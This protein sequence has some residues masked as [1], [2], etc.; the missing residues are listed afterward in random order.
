[1]PDRKGQQLGNYKLLRLLGEG[2]FAE[3]YLGEQVFVGTKAAI[4]I[5]TKMDRQEDL[6][7][8]IAEAK[9]IARLKHAHIV[10]MLDFGIEAGNTPYLVMEFAP[11]GSLESRYSK[12][13][14][15]SF[16]TIL[17][18]V[19]QLAEALDYAHEQ[20][21]VHRDIKPANMLLDEQ[22]TVLLSDFGIAV[23]ALSTR[24]QSGQDFGGTVPY[25]APE[26]LLGK[27]HPASDQYAL[28][29]AVYQWLTGTRPF[30]GSYFELTSQHLHAPPPPL[31][32]KLPGISPAVEK[33]V[34]KTLAKDPHERF[35]TV[36]AFAEALER[37]FSTSQ[38]DRFS[39]LEL[40]RAPMGTPVQ[41][42]SSP[43]SSPS[44]PRQQPPTGSQPSAPSRPLT[45]APVQWPPVTMTPATPNRS[46]PPQT[47]AGP[48]PAANTPLA[49]SGPVTPP[50]QKPAVH[51]PSGT[52]PRPGTPQPPPARPAPVTQ[53]SPMNAPPPPTA[54]PPSGKP[55]APEVPP[56]IKVSPPVSGGVEA[57]PKGNS[58]PLAP[59]LPKE[60]VGVTLVTYTGHTAEVRAVCWSPD[61]RYI[62]SASN[63][64]TVHIWDAATGRQVRAY[65]GHSAAIYALAW[66][67]GAGAGRGE[68]RVVS[69]GAD[70]TVHLWDPTSGHLLRTYQHPGIVLALGWSDDDTR[71]A[72]I[73]GDKTADVWYAKDGQKLATYHAQQALLHSLLWLPGG[74]QIVSGGSDGLVEVWDATSGEKLL[75]YRGH[76][77]LLGGSAVVKALACS[78][79]GERVAS[80]GSDKTVQVW[81][82]ASGK[83]L[84]TY[85]EQKEEV[86]ALAW[87][88][89]GEWIASAGDAGGA[90]RVWSGA[91]GKRHLLYSGHKSLVYSVAWSPDGTRIASASADRTV[92]VW[93][94]L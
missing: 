40:P 87:S 72:S 76:H 70:R 88:P 20:K 52:P 1:M 22:N 67:H 32:E 11:N 44:A 38:P 16:E 68:H 73:G 80:G 26:Q 46:A 6:D 93:Q 57:P 14:R 84:L 50:V 37:A 33:A 79:D 53:R 45:P 94:A 71:V 41:T 15:P 7:G 24:Y 9:T 13:R 69:G 89:K 19:K 58:S 64:K 78:P 74:Q 77:H 23:E 27:P 34:M 2:G 55:S 51:T 81:N 28:G 65:Q 90:V 82:S 4:K 75:S 30:H 31:R 56:T 35:A 86:L 42:P 54:R 91:S 12:D 63:D 83:H 18:Y 25:M 60:P 48:K 39:R 92:Q 21:V 61:G 10:R 36:L 29:I 17:S 62:A 66:W 43:G 47:P 49:R 85:H 3:V 8:F 5:L 59:S